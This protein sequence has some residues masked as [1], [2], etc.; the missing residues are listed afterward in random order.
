MKNIFYFSALLLFSFL[1]YLAIWGVSTVGDIEFEKIIFHLFMPLK[2]AHTDW[3]IGIWKVFVGTI[4]TCLVVFCLSRIPRFS[5]STLVAILIFVIFDCWYINKHFFVYDFIKS[6]MNSSDFI[7]KNY[8]FPDLKKISFP[9]NKKNL[10]II[11]VESLESSYQDKEN[12]GLLEKN[13]IPELTELAKSN[14]SFSFSDKIEG[15]FVPPETGWTISATVAQTAGIPLKLYGSLETNNK[16][17]EI[18]NRIGRYKYFLPGV[19]TLGD[20]LEKNGYRNYYILGT[21]ARYAGK[22][23]YLRQHGKYIIYDKNYIGKEKKSY[24]DSELFKFTEGKLSHISKKQPFSL[25]IQTIDTHF[26]HKKDFR[27]ISKMVASFLEWLKKQPFY[28]NTVIIVVG[29]HCNMK[30]TDFKNIEKTDFRYMGN[31]TRKVYNA[32]INTGITPKKQF[33]RRFSTFDIFP[34]LLASM[35]VKIEGNRLGLGTN[36]FSDEKTLFEIYDP[37]YAF[38]ELKK[39]SNWYNKNLL[40]K[41]FSLSIQKNK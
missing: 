25:L 37:E 34:T 20:I 35:G 31:M 18:D 29:D 16:E 38:S 30:H 11:M 12:G 5:K 24:S 28:Q 14:V 41:E 10:I 15:A 2:Q 9:Q 26:G 21:D 4:I 39:K 36:L 6:Q 8:V 22:S 40:Y 3:M 19:I 13:Y 17:R 23:T 27:N 32:F 33:N 1:G 7:E